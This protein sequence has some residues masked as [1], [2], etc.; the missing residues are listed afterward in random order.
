MRRMRCC[1]QLDR[2]VPRLLGVSTLRRGCDN[3]QVPF[4]FLACIPLPMRHSSRQNNDIL[5]V[6]GVFL[7][8]N[9]YAELSF[10]NYIELVELVCMQTGAGCPHR[11]TS[12]V[13]ESI[14]GVTITP[15]ERR[16]RHS[17]IKR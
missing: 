6:D 7:Q 10:E 9:L 11:Q 4:G 8:S 17:A 13:D 3:C 5:R 2:N 16:D 15:D 12:Y 1:V 14:V